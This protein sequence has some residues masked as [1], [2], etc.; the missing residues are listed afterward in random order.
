VDHG[1][2]DQLVA[3]GRRSNR[4]VARRLGVSEGTVRAR[5]RR[6]ED[7]GLLRICAQT[8]PY[9]TGQI[10]AWAYVGIEV[11]GPTVDEVAAKLATMPEVLIV[12]CTSGRH[13]LLVLAVAPSHRWLVD[14]IVDAIRGL[15]GVRATETW[16]VV[17]TIEHDYHW[18]RLV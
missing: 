2:I 14:T 17:R 13:D 7:A 5:L 11:D 15:D 18:A 10:G 8:D 12:A 1:V 16:D 4:E 3:D 6:M 9:L